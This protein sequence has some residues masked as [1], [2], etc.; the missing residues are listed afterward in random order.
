MENTYDVSMGKGRPDCFSNTAPGFADPHPPKSQGLAC[1]LPDP[2]KEGGGRR[3]GER[4]VGASAAAAASGPSRTRGPRA[5]PRPGA[6]RAVASANLNKGAAAGA[7]PLRK[8]AVAD[9]Q[10]AWP[11]PE[12]SALRA[13]LSHPRRTEMGAGW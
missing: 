6:S 12:L 1:Y 4:E 10:E 2:E 7:Q 5:G 9:F 11:R 3:E 13:P 8:V